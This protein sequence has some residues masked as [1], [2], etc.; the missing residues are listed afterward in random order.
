MVFF[1]FFVCSDLRLSTTLLLPSVTPVSVMSSSSSMGWYLR[2]HQSIDSLGY[3]FKI[4]FTLHGESGTLLAL[5]RTT[6]LGSWAG[7]R[8]YKVQNLPVAF[9]LLFLYLTRNLSTLAALGTLGDD[10][11]TSMLSEPTSLKRR[12]DGAG[13]AGARRDHHIVNSSFPS[14]CCCSNRTVDATLRAESKVKPV[15]SERDVLNSCLCFCV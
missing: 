5:H 15:M 10:Q 6:K 9:K 7:N 13:T 2:K 11:E 8:S 12:S 14:F 1:T 3:S 4:V